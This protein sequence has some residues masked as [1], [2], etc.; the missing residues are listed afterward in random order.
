MLQSFKPRPWLRNGHVQ[1]FA[2]ALIPRPAE[3]TRLE[4]VL[5]SDSDTLE[6]HWVDST[7][8]EAP[9]VLLLHGMEGSLDSPYIQG[10]LQSIKQI[11]WRGIVMLLRGCQGR[12]N[13]LPQ[14]YHA[15]KTDDLEFTLKHIHI[16]FPQ[17]KDIFVIGYSLGANQLL[18]FLGE[19]PQQHLLTAGVAVSIPFCLEGCAQN[20][21]QGFNKV[22][23]RRF[24]KSLKTT[25]ALKLE[26]NMEMPV[27]MQELQ[28]IHSLYDFDNKVTAPLH[29]F[30]DAKDYYRQSSCAQFLPDIKTPTL[31]VHAED[32]PFIP[33][34]SIPNSSQISNSVMLSIQRWGGH[35]GFVNLPPFKEPEHWLE[36]SIPSYLQALD[37]AR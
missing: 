25:V 21:H 22:Y 4:K 31:I 10:M 35:V 18:K 1:T 3:S 17:S 36:K 30:R 15:G 16:R 34:S 24:L 23:E 12:I 8:P 37:H 11:G 19:N 14:C 28:A 9:T 29:G 33:K 26:R 13:A 32:D 20:I 5:L 2:G 27:N 6:L 7:D